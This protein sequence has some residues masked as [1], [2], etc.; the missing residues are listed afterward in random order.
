MCLALLEEVFGMDV[1]TD[2]C[3]MCESLHVEV[4]DN[5]GFCKCI[6]TNCCYERLVED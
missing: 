2:E 5:G 1:G 4:I 3:P 6:C